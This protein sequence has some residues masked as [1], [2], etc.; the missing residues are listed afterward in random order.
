MLFNLK[1][2]ETNASCDP[3]SIPTP[4]PAQPQVP[5]DMVDVP[6][7]PERG[8]EKMVTKPLCCTWSVVLISFF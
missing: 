2:F 5:I 6:I 1:R 4:Y 7:K 3:V 8:R